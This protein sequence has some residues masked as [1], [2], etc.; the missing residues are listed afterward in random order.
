[1]HAHRRARRKGIL[2]PSWFV[3]LC[4]GGDRL[5]ALT[6]SA[7]WQT[8]PCRP[9]GGDAARSRSAERTKSTGRIPN[10]RT[11]ST[12][13]VCRREARS[14]ADTQSNATPKMGVTARIVGRPPSDRV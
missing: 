9:T 14:I 4:F 6:L 1:V 7:G 8:G 13:P 2:A 5:S 3:T 11:R 10:R 12:F